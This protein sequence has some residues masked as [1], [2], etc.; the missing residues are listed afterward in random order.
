MRR[1]RLNA[2]LALALL[3]LAVAAFFARE[4]DEPG[5]PLTPLKPDEITRIVLDHPGE[6]TL[7][8]EKQDGAWALTAPVSAAAELLEVSSLIGLAE[9]QI[10]QTLEGE[11]DLSRLNLDPPEFTVMLDDIEVAF[12]RLEPLQYR[13][14]V[15]IGDA[16]HLIEDPPSAA[17]DSDY[18]DLVAKRLFADGARIERVAMPK[19]TLSRNEDGTWAVSSADPTATPDR[20]QA[21]ADGW[22]DARSMWNELARDEKPKGDTVKVTLDG[23]ETVTFTVVGREPQLKLHRADIGVTYVLSR[24]LVEELLQLPEL[25]AAE[26]VEPE[27]GE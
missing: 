8:L 16:V 6:D 12:G 7:R 18:S 20:M 3:G 19:L 23:G 13:R 22:A 17:F 25:A 4:V 21:L 2:V 14:Y 1:N 24:A 9:R 27:T 15:R 10:R 11:V 5:A 26:A